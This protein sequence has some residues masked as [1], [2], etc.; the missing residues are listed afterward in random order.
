MSND[1]SFKVYMGVVTGVD[2]GDHSF[3][4]AQHVK[5]SYVADEI[6]DKNNRIYTTEF[7]K[8]RRPF[9]GLIEIR[10]LQLGSAIMVIEFGKPTTRTL[11]LVDQETYPV[12]ECDESPLLPRFSPLLPSNQFMRNFNR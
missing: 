4:T 11:I 5:Y 7:V 10:P 3:P 12:V 8:P 1:K 2:I 6:G 9:D